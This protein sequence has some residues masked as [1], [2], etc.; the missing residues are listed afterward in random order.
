LEAAFAEAGPVQCP[1]C[2]QLVED[3]DRIGSIVAGI[4]DEA[5][6]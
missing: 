4:T 5:D 1:A 2:T 6:D 3:A